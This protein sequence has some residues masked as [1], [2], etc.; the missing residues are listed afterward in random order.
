MDND[1]RRGRRG[2]AIT[3]SLMLAG[4]PLAVAAPAIAGADHIPE[5][6]LRAGVEVDREFRERVDRE[7]PGVFKPEQPGLAP[8]SFFGQ[9]SCGALI[10]AHDPDSQNWDDVLDG[11]Y[12]GGVAQV[13]Q[14]LI[15][16]WAEEIGPD[17]ARVFVDISI[18]TYCP[19]LI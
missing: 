3:A 14:N 8:L 17:D 12:Q 11:L 18:D 15:D 6:A 7:L 10:Y 19:S 5:D 1:S 9:T 13:R 4:A 16:M 2:F